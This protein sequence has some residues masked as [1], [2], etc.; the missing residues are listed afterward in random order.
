[1]DCC[2]ESWQEEPQTTRLKLSARPSCGCRTNESSVSLVRQTPTQ[3]LASL[4]LGQPVTD[5]ITDK[6]D[7]GLSW[8]LTA[9]ELCTTTQGQVDVTAETLRGWTGSTERAA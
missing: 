8:R 1:M 3:R 4:L 5:W 7:A 2:Q 9:R 6:R